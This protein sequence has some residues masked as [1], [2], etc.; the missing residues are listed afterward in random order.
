M[1]FS[2]AP[3]QV[4]LLNSIQ[5][6]FHQQQRKMQFSAQ[7][8]Y[9]SQNQIENC[10]FA[11]IDF[12]LT[13]DSSVC[14]FLQINMNALKIVVKMKILVHW[15][16]HLDTNVL[17]CKFPP[18]NCTVA[19]PSFAFLSLLKLQLFSCNFVIFLF[20]FHNSINLKFI[21]VVHTFYCSRCY[22]YFFNKVS[23]FMCRM[24]SRVTWQYMLI[25]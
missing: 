17:L 1:Q 15:Y 14:D 21:N 24:H 12:K 20:V 11:L 5:Q 18:P 10:I 7:N 22:F 8:K 9:I 2:I 25:V 16:Q 23:I 13:W 4:Q 19:P 6:H 3:K